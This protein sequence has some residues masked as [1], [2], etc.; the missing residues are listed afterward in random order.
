V[1]RLV[2]EILSHA[3]P[4]DS[5]LLNGDKSIMLPP[6]S[7]SIEIENGIFMHDG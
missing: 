3:P 1:R 6:G 7:S 4:T 5:K 2:L